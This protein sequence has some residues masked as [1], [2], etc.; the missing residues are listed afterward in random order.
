MPGPAPIFRVAFLAWAAL[1]GCADSAPP[2]PLDAADVLPLTRPVAEGELYIGVAFSGGGHRASA[3]AFGVLQELAAT[4][5]PANRDGLASDVHFLAGVS[6]G[7][8]VATW[9]ALHGAAGLASFRERY[10]TQDGDRYFPASPFSPGEITRTVE[11][12]IDARDSF[13]RVLDELL[14]KGATFADLDPA[15]P[16]LRIV[17]SDVSRAVP[18]V[19][20]P[21]T[22][23][24]LCTDLARLPLSAAV[25]ASAAFPAVFRP[26]VIAAHRR[27]CTTAPAAVPLRK[28]SSPRLQPVLGMLAESRDRYADPRLQ[29][30]RLW[31][32]GMTD[33][34]GTSGFV[35]ARA[36]ARTPH[37]PMTA[38]QAVRVRKILFL[39]VDA[40]HENSR[41]IEE[42]VPGGR[43]LAL[44]L[45]G[46]PQRLR[47]SG[48]DALNPVLTAR[49]I[50]ATTTD[51]FDTLHAALVDWQHEIV[52]WRCSLDPETAARLRGGALPDGWDCRDVAL[53]AGLVSPAGL[54][55]DLRAAMNEVPTRLRLPVAEIDMVTA[56]GRIAARR[57]VALGDLVR[58][59]EAG[60]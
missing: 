32:G 53:F 15:G 56:A 17:A 39:A 42:L 54:P 1:M 41:L 25:S 37:G 22:F 49:A 58:Q 35:A 44:S 51:G 20:S 30:V 38:E 19:F 18:F 5:A 10:L 40:S 28:L 47:D 7:S 60:R 59:L 13:G 6:G 8:V 29:S 31:D 21:P 57:T 27:P 11:D 36:S 9:F 23:A 48:K 46:L 45:Y 55:A 16:V 26:V 24:A 43:T 2:E 4:G 52:A 3:F 50:R 12:G 33:I 14:F 34:F